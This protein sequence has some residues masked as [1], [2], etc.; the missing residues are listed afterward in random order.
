M[1]NRSEVMAR[2]LECCLSYQK[3]G[4]SKSICSVTGQRSVTVCHAA[5]GFSFVTA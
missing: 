4:R 2:K 5:P 3:G 1:R